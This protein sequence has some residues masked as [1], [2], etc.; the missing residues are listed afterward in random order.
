MHAPEIWNQ[1]RTVNVESW[2]KCPKRTERGLSSGKQKLLVGVYEE[3]KH[4]IAKKKHTV[5][6][7]KNSEAPW[8][9]NLQSV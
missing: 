6:I 8:Q 7:N 4:I 3:Y 9:K 2:L 5:T 1:P